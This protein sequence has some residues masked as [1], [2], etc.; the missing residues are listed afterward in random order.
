MIFQIQR[1]ADG[2]PMSNE[3]FPLEGELP[4]TG[5]KKK[6]R[7][8]ALKKIPVRGYCW[9]SEKHPNTWFISHYIHKKQNKLSDSDTQKVRNN[10]H[11]IEIQDDER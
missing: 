1:L 2:H 3:N 9:K 7:F 8:R 11:R 4:G 10:W 5:H 6:Q